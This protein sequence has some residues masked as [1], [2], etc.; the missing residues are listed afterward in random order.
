[1]IDT[2]TRVAA[3]LHIVLGLMTLACLAFV[4]VVFGLM[5]WFLH[6]QLAPASVGAFLAG[7]GLLVM[8]VIGSLGLAQALAGA[9]LLRGRPGARI[10]VIVFGVLSLANVPIG[11]VVGAYTLWALLREPPAPP[12]AVPAA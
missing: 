7:I 6:G 5:G 2:H 11:T 12:A 1:M 9:L 4:T 3:I 10:A 8:G